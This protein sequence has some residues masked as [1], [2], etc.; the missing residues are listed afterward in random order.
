VRIGTSVYNASRQ[1]SAQVLMHGTPQSLYR[2]GD[3]KVFVVG[4]PDQSYT[5]QVTNHTNGRLLVVCSIDQRDV[6]SDGPANVNNGGMVISPFGTTVFDGWRHNND[7]VGRFV[8]GEPRRSVAAQ[9]TGSPSGVGIIGFAVFTEAYAYR[10]QVYRGA[11]KGVS[12]GAGGLMDMDE[13]PAGEVL[14]G[15]PSRGGVGTGIGETIASH[16]TTVRFDR[17]PGDPA[18]LEIGYD[19]EEWLRSQGIMGPE[20]P[21]AFPPVKAFGTYERMS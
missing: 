14:R 13:V 21:V 1:F 7:E 4:V 6:L 9:A 17:A 18:I 20:E 16:V 3:G 12:R 19:T 8:F 5:L 11:S 15:G 10:E 2:R